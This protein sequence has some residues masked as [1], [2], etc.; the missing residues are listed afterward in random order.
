MMLIAVSAFSQ[1]KEIAQK[2]KVEKSEKIKMSAQE[3]ATIASKKM[4]LALDLTEA[5]RLEVEKLHLERIQEREG[6]MKERQKLRKKNSAKR[7]SRV[8]A[9]LDK[10]LA[11]SE[12]MKSILTEEQYNQWKKSQQRP[13]KK[14]IAMKKKTI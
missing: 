8:N 4:A 14:K 2:D 13:A 3:R 5:Q 9:K 12:K 10:Q 11:H 7:I 6:I 1:Q